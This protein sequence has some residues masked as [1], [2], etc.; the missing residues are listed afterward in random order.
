VLGIDADRGRL[1]QT[2]NNGPF[3]QAIGAPDA[4]H[5]QPAITRW[6]LFANDTIALDRFT[7]TPGLRYDHNS[8]IGAFV[9]PSLGATYLLGKDTLARASVARGFTMP[10][11]STTSVG[12]LFLDPNPNLQHESVWSY[13]AG[14]ESALARWGWVKGTVFYHD[15]DN[16]IA[17]QRI[18]PGPPA[19]NDLPVN[20]GGSKRQGLELEAETLPFH[21]FAVAAGL[22][23]VHIKSDSDLESRDKYTYSLGLK[24]DDRKTMQAQV[25]GHYV[26][27]DLDGSFQADYG[28]FIWDLN[29]ARKILETGPL[30]TGIF[31]TVHNLFNSDQYTFVDN[32]NPERWL[33]AGLNITF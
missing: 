14:L 26:W 28:N 1:D 23:Y 29:V 12:G 31:F 19:N 3:L 25:F 8:I 17:R 2:L 20:R 4:T 21:D 33:E 22:A 30:T 32:K 10:P 9:S 27:W 13:Q 24:Y 5:A 11:L 15:L 7:L 18:G 16:A 6:A